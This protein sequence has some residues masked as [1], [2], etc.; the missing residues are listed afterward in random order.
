[1]NSQQFESTSNKL[2]TIIQSYLISNKN[3]TANDFINDTNESDPME[4]DHTSRGKGKIN[5]NGT[6]KR[7]K[8]RSEARHARQRVLRVR[9][10]RALRARLLV[11]SKLR[12][13]SERGRRCKSRLRCRKIVCACDRERRQR[14]QLEPKWLRSSRRRL[15]D[16]RQPQSMSVP[17]GYENRFLRNQTDQFN[18]EVRTEEHSKIT[19]SVKSG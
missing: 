1:M 2:R 3:W 4:V 6:G 16:D 5:G 8:Q 15:G 14:R 10:E 7:Q 13:N 11:P 17:S 9:K 19:E 12:Q 18:S